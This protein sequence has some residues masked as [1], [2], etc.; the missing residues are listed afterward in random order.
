MLSCSAVE[1]GQMIT[2]NSVVLT[3]GTFLR[4][5]IIIGM[6]SRPAGRVGDGPAVGLAKSLDSAGFKLGRLKT[7]KQS[8]T[9]FRCRSHKSKFIWGLVKKTPQICSQLDHTR[10]Q[11][12]RMVLAAR[13]ETEKV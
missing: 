12:N 6:D 11:M 13:M 1:N 8:V 4:G 2:G 7:G 5:E 9:V 10:S 3:T